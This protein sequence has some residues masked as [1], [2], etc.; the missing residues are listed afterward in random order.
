MVK[1]KRKRMRTLS[2]GRASRAAVGCGCGMAGVSSAAS[3]RDAGTFCV[4]AKKRTLRC[5]SSEKRARDHK[6]AYNKQHKSKARV[7]RDG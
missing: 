7:V 6:A 1:R 2:L 4:V 5:Y 3:K